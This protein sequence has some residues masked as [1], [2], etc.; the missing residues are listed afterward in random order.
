MPTEDDQRFR[1]RPR[2]EHREPNKY[3][4]NGQLPTLSRFKDGVVREIRNFENFFS[5]RIG[6]KFSFA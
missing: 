1:R 2:Y 5:D 4:A 3:R 6:E